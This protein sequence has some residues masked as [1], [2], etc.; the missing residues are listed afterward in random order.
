MLLGVGPVA[1]VVV[2]IVFLRQEFEE[3]ATTTSLA[4]VQ[5]GASV[6]VPNDGSSLPLDLCD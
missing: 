6:A 1:A 2:L 5:P 3:T 4:D